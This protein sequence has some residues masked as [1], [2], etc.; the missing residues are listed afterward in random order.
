VAAAVG[1]AVRRPGDLLARYGGEE[2]AVIL[3]GTYLA[4][5]IE[6]A[7]QI[8]QALTARALPHDASSFGR[9]TASIGAACMTPQH[10]ANVERLTGLADA[11]LYAAKR[12][13]RNRVH[14]AEISATVRFDEQLQPLAG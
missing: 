8:L 6:V 5:A 10:G 2:F 9:V 4:G 12:S 14:A 11:A 1:S 13:G 3:P 7:E